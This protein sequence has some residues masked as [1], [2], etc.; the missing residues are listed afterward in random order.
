MCI[1]GMPWRQ[2][3]QIH[4][5]ACQGQQQQHMMSRGVNQRRVTSSRHSL[6]GSGSSHVCRTLSLTTISSHHVTSITWH[7]GFHH[8][9]TGCSEQGG[10]IALLDEHWI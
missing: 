6:R 10:G 1:V 5:T 3:H 7:P 4:Y 9:D 2:Q 8:P